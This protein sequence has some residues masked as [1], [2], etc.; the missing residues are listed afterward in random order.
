M[1]RTLGRAPR[2]GARRQPSPG[3]GAPATAAKRLQ[4]LQR[5]DQE[6]KV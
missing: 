1:R 2:R 6:A 4:A 3:I 5:S